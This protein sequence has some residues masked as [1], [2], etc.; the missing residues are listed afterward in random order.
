MLTPPPESVRK[1]RDPDKEKSW[2]WMGYVLY[3]RNHGTMKAWH[4]CY[5]ALNKEDR[6]IAHSRTGR[7]CYCT[8]KHK[9]AGLLHTGRSRRQGYYIQRNKE[10]GLSHT[11]GS[12]RQA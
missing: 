3:W 10:A 1:Q 11:A 8:Q 4:V 12:R 7:Q 2:D 6:V 9:E 5:R